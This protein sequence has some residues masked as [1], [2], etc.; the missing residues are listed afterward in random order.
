[1]IAVRREIGAVWTGDRELPGAEDLPLPA[2]RGKEIGES[3][4]TLRRAEE[5]D[6]A[7]FQGIM[8]G[9]DKT[10]LEFRLKIDEEVTAAE[11]VEPGKG[12]ILDHVLYRKDD[13]LPDLFFYPEPGL[14]LDKKTPEPFRG[15][16]DGDVCRVDPATGNRDRILI[17]IR[18]V[19]LDPE[20]VPGLVKAFTEDHRDRVGFLARRTSCN[21]DTEHII[22]RLVLEHRGKDLCFEELECLRV[23]EEAGYVDKQFLEQQVDLGRILG[24]VPGIRVRVFKVVHA[25]PPFDAAADRVLLIE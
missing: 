14:L 25:H 16:I 7:G 9:R 4:D 8:E 20:R 10:V 12:G 22:F 5:K 13:H 15:D 24:K 3:P 11:E 21:P 18:A 19:D 23:A 1:M 6:P 17:D 2:D